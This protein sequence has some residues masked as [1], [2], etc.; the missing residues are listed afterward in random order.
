M[1]DT[2][3]PSEPEQLLQRVEALENRLAAVEEKLAYVALPALERV[4]PIAPPIPVA[5]L[6]NVKPRPVAAGTATNGR[7][8]TAPAL[9][10]PTFDLEA[11][12][13]Q[14]W[15]SWIGGIVLL[16]GICF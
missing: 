2:P 16:L 11:V 4:E 8:F 14:H 5:A 1:A 15:A 9:P 3:Q 6:D 7:G 12:I 10:R 13:G